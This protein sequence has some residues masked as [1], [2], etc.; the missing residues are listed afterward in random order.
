MPDAPPPDNDALAAAFARA[1]ELLELTGDNPHRVRNYA[2]V[3]RTLEKLP[4][5][6]SD[7]LADGTL[8]DVKGIGEGTASR[9]REWVETGRLAMLDELEAKV[10]AGLSEVL[11]VP[12]LG[13]KRVRR[14]WTELGVTSLAELEYAC[15]E[16]RLRDL[17]GFGD[18]TQDNVLK[19]IGF[20][21]RSRGLR[22]I[23]TARDAAER[24]LNRL[25]RDPSALRLAVAGDVRRMV[26]T[27]EG[28]RLLATAHDAA[29]LLATFTSMSFVSEVSRRDAAS[30]RVVLEDGT[31]VELDVVAEERFA[32]AWFLRTGSKE[33]VDAMVGRLGARGFEV[34]GDDLVHG[35]R[36]VAI[37]EEEAIYA[38]AQ[39][40]Y[41]PPERREG[42]SVTRGVPTDLLR[43]ADVRGVLHAHTTWSDGR[44]SIAEMAA[45]ARDL[46]FDWLA[47]CDHSEAAT[48]AHGLDAKRLAE[49]GA[50]IDALNRSGE[51]AVPVLKGIEADILPDGTLDLPAKA[52]D[53]LDVVIGSVH[54]AM[55]Q[56]PAVMTERLV[57]AVASGR[58]D[59]LGH[60][61]GRLLL[62]R[63]GFEFDFDRVFDACA[64]AGA[65][66]ELNANPHRL[67]LDASL[68]PAVATRGIPIAI[69]PDAHDLRGIEDIVYGVG[70]ARR[71]GLTKSQV[72]TTLDV[73][74]FRGWR[75]KRRGL[76]PPPPLVRGS[77]ASAT[78]ARD[79]GG[80]PS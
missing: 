43:A 48:Y 17:D 57:K 1:S 70:A 27:V 37:D 40:P 78:A 76:P 4:R 15:L 5:P 23:S 44:Y 35:G 20:L 10:P 72:L 69:D 71:A 80:D 19:G 54:S 11:T 62:G 29:A 28:V 74:A 55:S 59:V 39:A 52:L 24:V 14:I 65:A 60:P 41:V 8:L 51:A 50:E 13:P 53:A 31:P 64:K 32:L 67:D 38:M 33:H 47:I 68:L 45:R 18:K 3:A 34:R 63:Q 25:Q 21:K 7:M 75:A 49:Q 9:V 58:I 6:A 22:L 73:E 36:R 2:S 66:V 56:P 30:A 42:S 61:T 79:D 12:G 46:G 26:S 77:S 16:N